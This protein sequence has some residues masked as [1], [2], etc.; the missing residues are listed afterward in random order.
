MLIVTHV[1]VSAR[2][3]WARQS[4]KYYK[5]RLRRLAGDWAGHGRVGERFRD[6]E[7]PYAEDLDLFGR[8]SLFEM[9]START[10]SGESTLARWLL[11][12]AAPMD[13]KARQEAVIE[14]RD[15]LDLRHDLALTGEHLRTETDPTGL[16]QWGAGRPLLLF[17]NDRLVLFLCSL[18]ALATFLG[19]F[20]GLLT[21]RP[22]LGMVVVNTALMAWVAKR[23][24][25]ATHAVDTP[26]RDLA[27]MAV[28]LARLE[29]EQF[30][31]PAL[32][33][34]HR[35]FTTD[36]TPA[37]VRIARLRRL[38]EM[39]DSAHNMFFAPVAFVLLWVPQ[40]ALAI[41]AWRRR[42]GAA[43]NQWI[44]ALGELEALCS[45]AGYLYEHP[46][47]VFAE[48]VDRGP[49]FEAN[50]LA[51]P[52]LPE[53]SAVPNDLTL[54]TSCP[55]LIV[56]GSNMSGKSTLLRAVGL[57][58]VLAWAGAP[59]RARSLRVSPLTLGAS[60][61]TLDSIQ[62][63]R[64][65]FF[66][67]ITRLRQITALTE[68]DRPV[69]FLLDE[70]LSGTNSHDRR[71]GAEAILKGLVSRGAAGLAT[72]HDLA[73]TQIAESMAPRAANVHF[74]DV[75]EAGQ[76]R[77]DYRLR[78]GVVT[79]SNALELMRSIGLDV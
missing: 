33:A 11:A 42:N 27:L 2:V 66:A 1:R 62:E 37:S 31:T 70:L 65:R 47:A 48:F 24:L 39:L 3:D 14:L 54:A 6:P 35:T 46:S 51:H 17:R 59:V 44:A 67:E 43:V 64:S 40:F 4:V 36:S 19:F 23:A 52:L 61:R 69:L 55:L 57:N 22:F 78:Q 20:A 32:A 41:E 29:R 56:S 8:G 10:S 25:A 16:S 60:I 53:S 58:T 68:Q 30:Q 76:M 77:F 5:A 15:R 63:G 21:L 71:I 26:V 28:L 79:H 73:L 34:L 72:T 12:P 7:H 38:V 50:G 49:L 45:L 74:E 9:I 75:L 18:A 13:I